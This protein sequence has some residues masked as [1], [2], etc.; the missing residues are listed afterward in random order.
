MKKKV[1][2]LILDGW[3]EA[4]P[5]RYNAVLNANTPNVDFLRQN[6][7]MMFLKAE[8]ESVGLMEGQ[9]G[10]SEVNHLAIG[11]GRIIWQ[12]LPKLDKMIADNTFFENKTILN[13]INHVKTNNSS[14]H[15]TGIVSDGGVHSHINH[16]IALLEVCKRQQLTQKVFIHVFT[17]GRD[18]PPKSAIKYLT[19]LENKIN[20][21]GVGEIATLQGRFYLDRDRD[22]ARTENAFQLIR[23]GKGIKINSWREALDQSYRE[24]Q[25]D[26]YH[27][28][29][30]INENAK[31]SENDGFLMFN[32]RTDRSFQLLKRVID[33]KINNFNIT[34]FLS[35]SA[36]FEINSILKR[37]KVVNTLAEVLSKNGKTQFHCSETEKFAHVTYFF[38]AERETEFEGEKWLLHE[39]NKFV[40]PDYNLEPT[41]RAFSLYEEIIKNIEENKYDFQIINFPN[42][43]MV[44][45]TGS[46][47]AAVIAAESVDHCIGKIFNTLKD[48]L[49]SYAM[50]VTADHGNSDEMW[51]YKNNQP[52]TQHTLNPVPFILISDLNC[53]LEGLDSLSCVSPTILDLMGIEK[54]DEMEGSSLIKFD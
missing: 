16:L 44:G 23:S 5:D 26:Q 4:K 39:S 40:K 42:T 11:T 2:L 3:G 38:N 29:Y 9:M 51:D 25:D 36:E 45:H 12:D 49:D 54:P 10:T 35:P 34:C 37:D 28:Q 18:T 27:K 19:L 43:D 53:K 33:E 32:F 50:I 20:E 24:V 14:L 1:I 8:G 31:L 47:E 15:I 21:I 30:V 48:K 6:F 52:H 22:W 13:L 17:D 46:Y 41:M 7:P